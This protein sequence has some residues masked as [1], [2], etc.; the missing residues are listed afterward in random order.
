MVA[1]ISV[2]V[3][4]D[5]DDRARAADALFGHC[6]PTALPPRIRIV[7]STVPALPDRRPDLVGPQAEFWIDDAGV[8]TRQLL[9]T[10]GT[11]RGDHIEVTGRGGP[12]P[13]RA[14]R[15]AVQFPLIDAFSLHDRHVIHAAAV[16]RDGS[17]MLV[18]GGSGA[19]KSTFAFGAGQHGWRIIADDLCVATL[20]RG[21]VHLSG[22]PKPVN[23]PED[24]LTGA[25]DAGTPIP[26][27]ERRRWA[28]PP[29][30]AV[31]SGRYPV[32]SVVWV[33]HSAGRSLAQ[34][35]PPAMDRLRQL[36]AAHPLILLPRVMRSYFPLAG[37]LSRLPT[38]RFEHDRDPNRRVAAIGEFLDEVSADVSGTAH[39]ST[40]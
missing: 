28:L 17:A 5:S 23:V 16:E 18:L 12:D 38:H 32:H 11:R 4:L 8:A 20:Q 3:M 36:L 1:G 40:Q 7:E 29:A 39:R 13:I 33:G 19:G 31:A 27:D 30:T 26:L 34:V 37:R 9:G 15:L 25:P 21:T 35:G 2:S 24:V 6:E 10:T 22:F 14:Y